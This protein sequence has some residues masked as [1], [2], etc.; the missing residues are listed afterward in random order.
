[1]SVSDGGVSREPETGAGQGLPNPRSGWGL[2][3]LPGVGLH[4]GGSL[5]AAGGMLNPPDLARRRRPGAS[6]APASFLAPPQPH[7]RGVEWVWGS[8]R[9]SV[10]PQAGTFQGIDGGMLGFPDLGRTAL[11]CGHSGR[12]LPS[13]SP[14]PTFYG[15]D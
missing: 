12:R 8:A 13:P 2:G 10:D 1:M 11:A 9:G 5:T 6:R 14:N 15:V 4:A 3:L 7:S